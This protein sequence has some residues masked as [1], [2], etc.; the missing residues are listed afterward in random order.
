MLPQMG[1]IGKTLDA[2]T[3]CFARAL[4]ACG[5]AMLSNQGSPM[6]ASIVCS[7]VSQDGCSNSPTAT[8]TPAG[9]MVIKEAHATSWL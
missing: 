1:G 3:E 6:Y 2:L 8:S 7:L 4:E 9:L 5:V